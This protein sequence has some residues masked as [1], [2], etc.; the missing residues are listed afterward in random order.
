LVEARWFRSLVIG[1]IIANAVI[2][3]LLTS[4]NVREVGGGSVGQVLLAL[5]MIAL[6]FFVFEI[7]LKGGGLSHAFLP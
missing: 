2:L 5:D 7:A 4:K 3:G 1:V 6:G